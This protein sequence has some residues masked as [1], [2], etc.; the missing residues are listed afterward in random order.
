MNT[1]MRSKIFILF[2]IMLVWQGKGSSLDG[3]SWEA[4]RLVHTDSLPVEYDTLWW[5]DVKR[6]VKMYERFIS[7]MDSLHKGDVR[8]SL[9]RLDSL[10]SKCVC[11]RRALENKRIDTLPF[12]GV[13]RD[14]LLPFVVL[15]YEYPDTDRP[16][17]R[18]CVVLSDRIVY[19]EDEGHR[20]GVRFWMYRPVTAPR[21]LGGLYYNALPL[22]S[23]STV[24]TWMVFG[25]RRLGPYHRRKFI[26]V[27]TVEGGVALRY[28]VDYSREAFV[29]VNY[30]TALGRIMMDHLTPLGRH[31][32]GSVRLVP[33]GTYSAF[34]PKGGKW[35][36]VD[37]VFHAPPRRDFVPVP[38]SSLD[39]RRDLFGRE[40][41]VLRRRGA[42]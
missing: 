27:L 14:T 2:F 1:S 42:R 5:A 21:W 12:V 7:R 37:K 6:F 20:R 28:V 11:N 10:F 17:Y 8:E 35:Y 32:D 33:D 38:A 23:D 24:S 41:K 31:A 9:Q 40:R 29:H 18:A 30:D 4:A 36:Y 22:Y 15:T 13:V 3:C 26:D 19:L 25:Y 39:K 16:I 34:V